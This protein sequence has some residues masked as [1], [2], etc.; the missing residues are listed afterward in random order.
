MT[1]KDMKNSTSL[2]I[3]EM[4]VKT[5][6][7]FYSLSEWLQNPKHTMTKAGEDAEQLEPSYIS[8]GNPKWYSH[9]GKLA[10]SNKVKHILTVGPSS[11]T[12]WYLP[13]RNENIFT[14]KFVCKFIVVL[15]I[16]EKLPVAEIIFSCSLDK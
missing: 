15:F 1:N 16:I 13:E 2:V 4:Q 11:P 9:F 5:T 3:R 6:M 10:V 8:S 14:Q 12:P 7:T